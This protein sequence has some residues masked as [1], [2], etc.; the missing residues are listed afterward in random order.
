MNQNKSFAE[1]I[2]SCPVSLFRGAKHPRPAGQQTVRE[3]LTDIKGGKFKTLIEKARSIQDKDSYAAFK[4]DRLPSITF[5]GTFQ[6]RNNSSLN[7]PTGIIIPDIDHL[8]P[9]EVDRG[10]SLLSQDPYVLF[11]FRSPGGNGIKAG[12]AAEGIRNDAD[13]KRFFQAVAAYFL[14]RYGVQIDPACKDISRLTFVS[15]DPQLHINNKAQAF[16]VSDWI[17]GNA[18]PQPAKRAV[19]RDRKAADSGGYTGAALYAWK[20]IL[21]SCERIRESVPGQQHVTRLTE[22]RLVGGYLHQGIREEDA[23]SELESAVRDSGAVDMVKAMQTVKDG[24][25]HGRANPIAIP[26][27]EQAPDQG[28]QEP[29]GSA[30]CAG[31]FE[32][33]KNIGNAGCAGSFGDCQEQCNSLPPAPLHCFH[34]RIAQLLQ[35]V[36][37]AK[38]APIEAAIAPLLAVIAAMIGRAMGLRIKDGWI[39]FANLY[40]ALVALSGSGKSPVTS[41]FFRAIRK[42]E[43]QFQS[44][45]ETAL[46]RYELDLMQWQKDSK[47]KDANPAPK[48]AIPKREDILV[49]DWTVESLTETLAGNPWGILAYRDE[50]AGL[51]LELDKYSNGSGGGTKNRLMSAYDCGPWKTSRVNLNRVSYVPAACISIYGTIQPA[52]AKEIFTCIDEATGFLSRFLMINATIKSPAYFSEKTESVE[53]IHTMETLVN[54]LYDLRKKKG[55]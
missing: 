53:A 45:F 8:E 10:F 19:S 27:R 36:A 20:C 32:S 17:P 15:Y 2:L 29:A 18:Q 4:A 35:E 43:R 34:P 6:H 41:F 38:S 22:A 31:S 44:R 13:H 28:K 26:D 42:L 24:L 5:A 46:K 39:E 7:Q 25:E 9:G 40:L 48:P 12:L 54:G 50:L 52:Q 55:E 14:D 33:V 51:M 21:S 11:V 1:G 30:G 49:D 23:W 47:K 16:P 3:A 37:A